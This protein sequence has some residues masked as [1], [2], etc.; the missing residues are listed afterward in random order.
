MEDKK[1]AGAWRA[2]AKVYRPRSP[3]LAGAA[4]LK[5]KSTWAWKGRAV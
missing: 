5:R 4:Q 3:T 2:C 1:L